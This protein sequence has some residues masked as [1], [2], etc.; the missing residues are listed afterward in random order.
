MKEYYSTKEVAI[1]TKQTTRNIR[2]RLDKLKEEVPPTMLFK[3]AN[4][5]YQIHHL[6][7]PQLAPKYTGTIKQ[8]AMTFDILDNSTDEEIKNKIEYI[9]NSFN[10]V[11]MQYGIQLKESGMK[12]IHAIVE[13]ISK[14]K[15][16]EQIRLYFHDHTR[17]Y[18]VGVY[19]KQ[20]WLRYIG[21]DNTEIITINKTIN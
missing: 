18:V 1:S 12:H 6:L 15:F 14:S 9:T 13:G 4:N 3:D 11:K 17:V 5:S 8:Y 2:Y 20:G 19:D 21:R 16:R 7:L 10:A